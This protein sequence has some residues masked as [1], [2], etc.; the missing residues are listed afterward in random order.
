M[1]RQ[2]LRTILLL[3]IVFNCISGISAVNEPV[4]ID[5]VD[6]NRISNKKIRKLISQQ[7]QF[8]L[9]TFDEI[10]PVCYNALDS[11][12][13]RIYKKSQLIKQ[14]IDVVWD[15][16]THQ[17]PS[18]E[19][20]GKI[21]TFGMLYSKK[22]NNI[23]YNDETYSGL[24]EGQ[25]LFFNLRVLSGIKNLAVALEVTKMDHE[26]K[27]VEY[28]YVEHGDTKG[29][30]RF[31]LQQTAEGFTEITQFTRYKCKS[32][33]RDRRLYSFFHE[34]IVKEFLAKIKSK[35]EGMKH[36]SIEMAEIQ[37]YY[38]YNDM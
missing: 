28:C 30:Q 19:F 16:L 20:N 7:K 9:K 10:H 1:E 37:D 24:E 5:S 27:I 8:G 23:L 29:T 35:S 25:I 15:N 3:M 14:D 33:L 34:R 2:L 12:N 22:Y 17:S 32:K 6:Y 4:P 13:F 11:N 31:S 36:T 38:N 26:N 21:V 18:S